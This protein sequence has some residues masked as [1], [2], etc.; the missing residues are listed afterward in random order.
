MEKKTVECTLVAFKG[1]V[2]A[3]SNGKLYRWCNVSING[4]LWPAMIYESSYKITAEGETIKADLAP[5]G[6]VV[7]I[8]AYNPAVTASTVVC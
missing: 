7:M 5:V 1:E 8:T 2:K 6:D 4:K 3:N